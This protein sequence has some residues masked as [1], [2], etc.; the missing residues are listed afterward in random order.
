MIQYYVYALWSYV[1]SYWTH[2]PVQTWAVLLSLHLLYSVII[3]RDASIVDFDATIIWRPLT[4]TLG[5]VV[6]AF[7][8]YVIRAPRVFKI[9][10]YPL[11]YN[12]VMLLMGA[13]LL[14][15][16]LVWQL[17]PQRWWIYCFPVALAQFVTILLSYVAVP[18]DR[19]WQ[20]A[21]GASFRVHLHFAIVLLI[22]LGT[23]F[24]AGQSVRSEDDFWPFYYAL[25]FFGLSTFWS[26]MFH[27]HTYDSPPKMVS[28]MSYAEPPEQTIE[29][30]Y[31]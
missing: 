9:Y 6:G 7:L 4:L 8:A 13:V 2:R 14:G 22:I 23:P 24:I 19:I 31:V 15:T 10:K 5:C 28:T 27:V 26:L 20:H 30:E 11:W 12:L 18:H 29:Q 25:I 16:G 17:A 1:L 21:Q 3:E